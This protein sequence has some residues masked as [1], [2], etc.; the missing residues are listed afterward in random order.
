MAL[1]LKNIW[2]KLQHAATVKGA[3]LRWAVALPLLK[4]KGAQKVLKSALQT[5]N[6]K[7]K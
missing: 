1:S 5:K 4:V 3:M 7:V 2:K 6:N